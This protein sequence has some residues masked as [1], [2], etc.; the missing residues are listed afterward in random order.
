MPQIK[1]PLLF[2]V[3][4]SLLLIPLS[5]CGDPNGQADLNPVTG[6][7]SDPAWLPT[8]HTSAAKDHGYSCT[9]CHGEDLGGGISKVACT[10]CHL[11][12]QQKVHPVRWGAY[13]YALHS[14]FVGQNGSASCA[15]ASCHGT[16]LKGVAGSGPSCS[17]CHL[18]GP[19][20]AHPQSWNSDIISRHPGYV[21]NLPAG[22]C[23]TAVCH[24]TDLKGVFLSGPS[25][26]SCHPNFQ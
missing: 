17:S 14:Q 9:V 4:W 19:T 15:A 18:G 23:A 20:S 1:T 25:C 8:G 10:K 7:H 16:D 6:K 24:G 26:G 5:G 11:G 13:A 2:L 3:L 12:N 22:S 21:G